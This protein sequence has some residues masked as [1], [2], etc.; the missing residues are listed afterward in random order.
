MK[1]DE[2]EIFESNKFDDCSSCKN[3]FK[4][5]ICMDCRYGEDFEEEDLDEVDK[6]FDGRI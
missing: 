1:D 5:H 2:E 3:R 6:Y 4:F